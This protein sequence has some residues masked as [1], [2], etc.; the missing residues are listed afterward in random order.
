MLYT[1]KEK[2]LHKFKILKKRKQEPSILQ[3]QTDLGDKGHKLLSFKN[4][5]NTVSKIFKR[6]SKKM[7]QRLQHKH[8]RLRQ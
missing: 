2:S 4:S 5:D 1:R 6:T 3:P 7:T 8:Q